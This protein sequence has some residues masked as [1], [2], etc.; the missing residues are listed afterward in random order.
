M[1]PLR[2]LSCIA[3]GSNCVI[4][5]AGDARR[6]NNKLIWWVHKYNAMLKLECEVIHHVGACLFT[7]EVR[8]PMNT[9]YDQ[10]WLSISQCYCEL[11]H[12]QAGMINDTS[13]SWKLSDDAA[14]FVKLAVVQRCSAQSSRPQHCTFSPTGARN[15]V[16]SSEWLTSLIKASG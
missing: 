15:V 1:R 10:L 12:L 6:I 9:K 16:L 8:S 5:H 11:S 4:E 2:A 3:R 14:T 13:P 7:F